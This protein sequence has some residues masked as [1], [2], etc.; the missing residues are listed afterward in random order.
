[1]KLKVFLNLLPFLLI[2]NHC[3]FGQRAKQEEDFSSIKFEISSIRFMSDEERSRKAGDNLDPDLVLKKRL[4][5]QGKGTFYLYIE[6]V[7]TLIP[8]GHVVKKTEKGLFWEL[9]ASG[10]TSPKS[11]G[12]SSRKSGGWL[13]LS[14]G[15]AIEWEGLEISSSTEETHAQTVFMKL[16]DKG[17]VVEIFSNFYQVPV[18][19][20]K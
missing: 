2:L 4:S 12:F 8:A 20:T 3:C 11:P 1:M 15:D 9:D 14:E 19:D 17:K 5:N 16:G 10:K 7:N 18:T 13:M 6:F